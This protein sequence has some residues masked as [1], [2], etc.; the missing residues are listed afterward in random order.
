MNPEVLG[1]HDDLRD[2]ETRRPEA[3]VLL[4]DD[5]HRLREGF[6]RALRKEPYA[7]LTAEDT[8]EADR[9]MAEH[10]V[11]VVVCD[12]CM[13][14]QSGSAFLAALRKRNPDVVRMLL[15]GAATT[16]LA[17]RA[18]NDGEVYRFLTKPCHPAE[19]GVAI[20]QGLEQKA[21]IDS[22]RH[23]LGRVRRQR[24]VI[25][26]LE[27]DMPGI[28]DIK[29]DADGAIVAPDAPDDLDALL[30]EVVEELDLVESAPPQSGTGSAGR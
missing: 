5:D 30:R 28:S 10:E 26:E 12:E 16:D 7:L 20:R 1:P 18:I 17:I 23:L 25:A 11:A 3:T 27:R 21:L 19:L 8:H 22:V 13:P 4:V 29:T 6:A 24:A 2:G 15:T 14:G 9:L